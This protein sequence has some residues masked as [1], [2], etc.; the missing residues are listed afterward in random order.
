MNCVRHHW[1]V[2]RAQN[3]WY[4]G[5]TVWCAGDRHTSP[6][7]VTVNSCSK[8]YLP[9]EMG[10]KTSLFECSRGYP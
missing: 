2:G 9:P 3:T 7:V 8:I 5:K 4:V 10:N 1:S 6:A